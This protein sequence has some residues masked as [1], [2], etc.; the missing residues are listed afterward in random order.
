MET[1][2]HKLIKVLEWLYAEDGNFKN[3]NEWRDELVNQLRYLAGIEDNSLKSR[4]KEV[5][6]AQS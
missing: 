4:I 5:E 3:K 2:E 1:P 6:D